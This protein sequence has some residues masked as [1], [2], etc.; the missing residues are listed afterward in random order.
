MLLIDVATPASASIFFSQIMSLITLQF[1]D[2]NDFFDSLFEL[3][4]DVEPLTDQFETLG[5]ESLYVYKNLGTVVLG[6]V[7]PLLLWLAVYTIVGWIVPQFESYKQRASNMI[8]WDKTFA[9]IYETY[10]LLAMCAALNLHYLKWDSWGN[11]YN[12]IT[13]LVVLAVIFSFPIVVGV[14]YSNPTV[15]RKVYYREE[16]F[17]NMFG[18]LI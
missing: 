6:I 12:S 10:I 14:F 8:F 18:S 15:F 9:F 16:T 4:L 11:I 3:D 17:L 5:Y 7:T 13:T 2:M 1:W